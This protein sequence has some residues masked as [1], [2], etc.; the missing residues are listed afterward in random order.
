MVWQT[1]IR[2]VDGRLCAQVTLTQLVMEAS[3]A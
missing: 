2:N 3:P 1:S